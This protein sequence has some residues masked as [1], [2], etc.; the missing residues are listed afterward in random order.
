VRCS[1]SS[2]G[3]FASIASYAGITWC[4]G[5]VLIFKLIT[6]HFL[7]FSLC[8]AELFEQQ[9]NAVMFTLEVLLE[10]FVYVRK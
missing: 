4:V 9:I 3:I 1:C 2:G 8:Q 5:G 6:S 7:F 10:L